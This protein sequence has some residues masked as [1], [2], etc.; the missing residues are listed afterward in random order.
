MTKFYEITIQTSVTTKSNEMS[1]ELNTERTFYFMTEIQR[2]QLAE[3][4]VDNGISYKVSDKRFTGVAQAR[5]MIRR[6]IRETCAA[7]H[8]P[9]PKLS[10]AA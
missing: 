8:I 2:S 4:C 3:W 7:L 6:D 10:D 1:L 5:L 9:E